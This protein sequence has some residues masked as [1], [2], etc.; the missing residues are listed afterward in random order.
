MFTSVRVFDLAWV[1]VFPIE[2]SNVDSF[3]WIHWILDEQCRRFDDVFGVENGDVFVVCVEFVHFVFFL[4][5]A[6][7]SKT[8]EDVH[9][10]SLIF[11]L[12]L[13]EQESRLL[14]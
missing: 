1:N 3:I 10:P 13:S 14:I 2:M 9:F 5:K 7:I 4:C 12:R 8:I 11:I 6:I